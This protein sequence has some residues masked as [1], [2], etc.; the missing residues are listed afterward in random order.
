MAEIIP[1]RP[2]FDISAEP[3]KSSDQIAFEEAVMRK[4]AHSWLATLNLGYFNVQ[5]LHEH[6][7]RGHAAS[8]P[9]L[10]S[11][12]MVKLKLQG[13]EPD[14]EDV[15]RSLSDTA[16]YHALLKVAKE[17]KTLPASYRK[18]LEGNEGFAPIFRQE[19]GEH[20]L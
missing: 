20:R 14:I 11:N 12:L 9:F 7:I 15:R 16:F 2:E 1:L 13:F 10:V 4:D 6:L 18:A 19:L 8:Q 17:Q 5:S 3:Y